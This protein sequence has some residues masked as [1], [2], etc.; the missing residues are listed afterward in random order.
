M[1]PRPAAQLGTPTDQS[2]VTRL[3]DNRSGRVIAV[4]RLML[5]AAFLLAL[6]IDPNQP[7]RSSAAGYTILAGYLGIAAIF[8]V[9]AWHSWWWDFRLAWPAHVVDVLA[10]L[11]AVFFTEGVDEDFTSPFLAF[12]AFL[13]LAATLRWGWRMT[14]ATAVVSTLLYLFV[15]LAM[16]SAAIELDTLRF[17]RR[18][19]YMIVLSMILIWL[20][21]QRR[22]QRVDRFVEPPGA[23]DERL[24]PLQ[25]AL[26]YAM[27][28]TD[29][30]RG[31]IAWADDEEPQIELRVIGLGCQAGRLPPDTVPAE[32][33]F[34]ASA[35]LFDSRRNRILRSAADGSFV[36]VSGEVDDALATYCG[37]R[38]GLALPFDAVTGRGVVLLTDIAGASADHV[39]VAREVAREIGA[40]FD[41]HSTLSL[42]REGAVTRMRDAVARDLH[43]T[44]AQS[45]AG[46]ALRLEGLR[47]WIAGGG[48]PETEIQSIKTALKGE[49]TQVRA[50]IDR[51]RRGES[52]LPESGVQSTIGPL[53][54]DL[55][56]YWGIEATL[57]TGS[58]AVTMPGWLAHELRQLVREAVANAVRHGRA[59]RIRVSL[60]E[61]EDA[62]LVTIADDGAGFADVVTVRRPRSI[63]ERV[64]QL[65]GK[66]ELETG[67]EG[68]TL[69]L[70]LPLTAGQ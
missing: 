52:V 14:V 65:G 58:G 38:E 6:W 57:D 36:T 63:S 2:I 27:T 24:P 9:I 50:M 42:V 66:L 51:L 59:R 54:R 11:S 47:N 64:A 55:A 48:D 61:N 45:L 56:S 43:D 40:G 46:A 1:P 4:T 39:A 53:L 13:M 35:R 7:A 28:Q 19:V 41:R 23:G 15:G 17:G 10:F 3:F 16:E 32:T 21:H 20:G 29:A 26:R 18:V 49:Q 31:A 68:T 67:V 62:L 22:F 60:E 34:A 30:Q 37:I 33:P 12:F 25:D 5:A 69:H 70:S 8:C 44:I